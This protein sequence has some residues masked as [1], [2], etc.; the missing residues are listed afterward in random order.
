[1]STI[2]F[3]CPHCNH[4]AN[5]PATSVGQQGKCPGCQQVVTIVAA[6]PP[7]QQYQQAPPPQ[8]YQQAP[9]PQ[10]YQQV[11]PPQQYQQVPPPQQYQQIPPQQY[12]QIPPPQQYQQHPASSGHGRR[13]EGLGDVFLPRGRNATTEINWPLRAGV[14]IF[15]LILAVIFI[16]II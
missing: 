16:A 2:T 4:T 13:K 14:A 5:L 8:Q 6:T 12:Q 3:I 15:F 10:Q 9:P 7:P 11:P 1:M